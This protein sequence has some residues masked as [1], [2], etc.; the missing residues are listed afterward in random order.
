MS[1]EKITWKVK[2]QRGRTKNWVQKKCSRTSHGVSTLL[3]L[4]SAGGG[5][6]FAD[7]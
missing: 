7:G 6:G 4:L 2:I 3:S 5:D 1:R